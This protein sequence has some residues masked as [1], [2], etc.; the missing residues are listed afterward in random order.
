MTRIT[1]E[2]KCCKPAFEREAL[3]TVADVPSDELHG[4]VNKIELVGRF[5]KLKKLGCA[6][7]IIYIVGISLI[8]GGA[9]FRHHRNRQFHDQFRR[10]INPGFPGDSHHP[11]PNFP[12]HDR[13]DSPIQEGPEPIPVPPRRHHGEGRGEFG[14]HQG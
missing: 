2:R 10:E 7:L 4:L 11:R 9:V 8:I 5:S 14:R 13:P 6:F 3:A 12:V 1:L